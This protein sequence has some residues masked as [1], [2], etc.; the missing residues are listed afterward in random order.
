MRS[1]KCFSLEAKKDA[2]MS[3]RGE[4]DDDMKMWWDATGDKKNPNE[5]TSKGKKNS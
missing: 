3:T 1:D 2:D 4:N 5:E